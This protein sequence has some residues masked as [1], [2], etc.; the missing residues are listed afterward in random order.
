MANINLSLRP[1]AAK[2]T[3]KCVTS[4]AAWDALRG[5]YESTA[6]VR[7]NGLY[8]AL[9]KTRFESF[10]SIQQYVDHILS[11]AEHLEA[12]GQPF[13]DNV[14]GG[15]ILGGLPEQ[16]RSLTLGIQGSKQTTSVKF[17]QKLTVA[18]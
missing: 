5:E 8:S 3:K 13:A 15:I 1:C 16:F 12:I 9:F 4:K 17:D 6:L 7:L 18:G 10:T 14:V 2:V 11:I